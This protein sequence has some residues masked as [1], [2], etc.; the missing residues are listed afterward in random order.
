[1]APTSP[2]FY[3]NAHENVWPAWLEADIAEAW[4]RWRPKFAEM[5]RPLTDALL[6][7][8]RI[9]RGMRIL[10]LASGA[11]E[12]ALAI[13][14]LVGTEGQVTATDLSAPM[15]SVVADVAREQGLTNI[16][17]RR[18][19]A[20]VLP[21]PDRAFDAVV[22]RLGIMHFTDAT[23]ALRESLRVLAG[24]GQATFLVW[25]PP[26]SPS[27][28]LHH[29]I[30][31]QHADVPGAGPNAAGPLRFALPGTLS[32]ALRE[33]G[34]HE[35]SESTHHLR[36]SWP[37]PPREIWQ[38]LREVS[39]PLRHRLA[40]IPAALAAQIDDEI[41]RALAP[42]GDA[43]HVHLSTAVHVATGTRG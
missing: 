9:H 22:S 32:A 11:G 14:R 1:M 35:I 16:T 39:A 7:A 4:R 38:H 6:H 27:M 21:F 10:D 29:G 5:S 42:Y 23:G 18:A 43:R 40:S 41:E 34:F 25:G 3:E 36:L 20:A 2:I 30:A 31:S 8:A 28:F 33:A 26:Q 17:C 13:A 15:L 24:G 37:G 19:D 12:P